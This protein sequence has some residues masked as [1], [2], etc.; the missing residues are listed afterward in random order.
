MKANDVLYKGN[1]TCSFDGSI[2]NAAIGIG[3]LGTVYIP[4]K[5]LD[6]FKMD[7]NG[8]YT[9]GSDIETLNI[10]STGGTTCSYDLDTVNSGYKTYKSGTQFFSQKWVKDPTLSTNED[11]GDPNIEYCVSEFTSIGVSRPT[12]YGFQTV[13]GKVVKVVTEF[14]YLELNDDSGNYTP[15]VGG[16]HCTRVARDVE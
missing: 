5:A 6:K 3:T 9:D 16:G 15:L 14:E 12:Q 2:N 7:G 4:N 11:S 1:Y 10:K 8:H 13:A